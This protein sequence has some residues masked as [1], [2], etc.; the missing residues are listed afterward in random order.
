M[1]AKGHIFT[2]KKSEFKYTDS[3][4]KNVQADHLCDWSTITQKWLEMANG[5]LLFHT[6]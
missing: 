6:L 5:L 1:L 2:M 3:Q 4:D